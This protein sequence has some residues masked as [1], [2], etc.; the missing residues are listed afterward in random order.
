M[1]QDQIRFTELPKKPE[2]NETDL[3]LSNLMKLAI[4]NWKTHNEIELSSSV[5]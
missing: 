3:K 5:L 4:Q 1:E 2:Q